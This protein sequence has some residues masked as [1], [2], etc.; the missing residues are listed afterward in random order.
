MVRFAEKKQKTV[1]TGEETTKVALGCLLHLLGP[2]GW[3]LAAILHSGESRDNAGQKTVKLKD[4]IKVPN[5]RLCN[6]Q[7]KLDTVDGNAAAGQFAF[8]VHPR[9]QEE[10]NVLRRQSM[11]DR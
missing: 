11:L 10:L 6:G 4:K 8:E 7:T 1:S 5:C 9:F 2:V 3:L